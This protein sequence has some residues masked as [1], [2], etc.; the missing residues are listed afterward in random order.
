MSGGPPRIK[1]VMT[2]RPSHTQHGSQ[3]FFE[4]LPN[5]FQPPTE[6]RLQGPEVQ[7]LLYLIPPCQYDS[8][9]L[10]RERGL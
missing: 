8:L 2:G 6:G 3:I 10:Y 5:S 9:G 1:N 7:N 4:L